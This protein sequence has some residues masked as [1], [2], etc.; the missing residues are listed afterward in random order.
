MKRYED[1]NLNR[2][3]H[4]AEFKA[5]DVNQAADMN[6]SEQKNDQPDVID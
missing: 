4:T 1:M 3:K 6:Q 5:A 2:T